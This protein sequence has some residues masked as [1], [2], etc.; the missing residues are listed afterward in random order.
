MG[1]GAGEPSHGPYGVGAGRAV[2]VPRRERRRGRR[3]ICNFSILDKPVE[4]TKYKEKRR[5]R[6]E[7][8]ET[9]G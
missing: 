3:R 2:T 1:G 6:A 7:A 5:R 4:Y 8:K 9:Q